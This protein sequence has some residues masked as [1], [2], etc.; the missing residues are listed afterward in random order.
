MR[1]ASTSVWCVTDG[2]AGMRYQTLA[3]ATIM[4]W[5][6]S[7]AFSDIVVKPHP[8]LRRVPR[9]G[10]WAP[11]LPVVQNQNSPLAKIDKTKDT[12]FS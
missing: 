4:K 1:K 10:R 12:L 6:Q 9:L 11:N 7:P 8:I 2:T 5:D 3:L